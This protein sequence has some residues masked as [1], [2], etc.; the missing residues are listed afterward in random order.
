[1]RPILFPIPLHY[2]NPAW[3]DIPVYG[4]GAML[5]LAFLSCTWLAWRLGRDQG[6][7]KE[8]VQDL[9][10][11]L[12]VSGIAG[13]RIDYLV[14][15]GNMADLLTAP[16]QFF[17]V[18][19]GGLVVYGA[20]LGA[21]IGYVLAYHYLLRK[22]GV[23]FW[24]MADIIAPCVALGL[25][26]GRIG[27]LLNGCCY[28]AV[29][30][31][32]CPA[33]EFPL[34]ANPRYELTRRGCQTAAGFTMEEW[35]AD[36]RT[37][38]QVEKDSPAAAAG[39]RAGDVIVQVGAKEIRTY[40]DLVKALSLEWQRDQRDLYLTVLRRGP[41]GSPSEEVALPAFTPWTLRLHPTQVYESISTG[42]LLLLLLAFMPYRRFEG[43]A[44]VLFMLCYAAHRFLNEMLRDD[45]PRG[46]FGL[47]P[48]QSLSVAVF[49]AGLLLGLWLWR[50]SAR[51]HV[52]GGPSADGR[53]APPTQLGAVPAVR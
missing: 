45:T 5:F 6:I 48:G 36:G 26:L 40:G 47:K 20:F 8:T 50:T 32:D 51:P 14:E 21:T 23:R 28:G 39:L 38:G 25:C 53:A 9:A 15:Y 44:F 41:I 29:A 16:L 37:V 52:E 34:C 7:T 27:C 24:Q 4:Y 2:L 11:W 46:V 19:K 3:P 31:A 49:A 17:E 33:L 43:Q 10:I 22:R 30:C 35:A 18:W 13:G 1:M 42:L 12:F